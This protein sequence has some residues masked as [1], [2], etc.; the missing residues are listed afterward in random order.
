MGIGINS[1]KE[2]NKLKPQLIK[3]DNTKPVIKNTTYIS[4]KAYITYETNI[5]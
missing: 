5:S 3:T 4:V 1:E 2:F